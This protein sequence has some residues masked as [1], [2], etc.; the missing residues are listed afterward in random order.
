MSGYNPNV[1]L[2]LVTRTFSA[3]GGCQVEEMR[4]DTVVN[5]CNNMFQSQL[6]K[7]EVRKKKVQPLAQSKSA[8]QEKKHRGKPQ[9]QRDPRRLHHLNR[10]K[11]DAQKYIQNLATEDESI[12]RILPGLPSGMVPSAADVKHEVDSQ[13]PSQIGLTPE[14]S[15]DDAAVQEKLEDT[16]IVG[17]TT[18]DK[19]Q[20]SPVRN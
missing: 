1:N 4:D 13:S 6:A 10:G 8:K 19:A 15:H 7:S 5:R 20:I 14:D 17:L 3:S 18:L 2:N 11:N 16:H 12:I 9:Q